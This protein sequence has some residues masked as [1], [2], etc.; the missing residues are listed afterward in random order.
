MLTAA[1]LES[2]SPA[3][4]PSPLTKLCGMNVE[5]PETNIAVR[6]VPASMPRGLQPGISRTSSRS[7]S[8]SD[9]A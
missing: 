5:R 9:A 6:P 2:T 7:V 3:W 1:R 8:S 4:M